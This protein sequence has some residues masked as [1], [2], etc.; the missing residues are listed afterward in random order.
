MDYLK[1]TLRVGLLVVLLTAFVEIPYAAAIIALLGLA[2]GV[3][4]DTG[5]LVRTFVLAIGLSICAGALGEIPAVG[6]Y[7]TDI[8]TSAAALAAASAVGVLGKWV[9]EQAGM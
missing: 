7:L 2:V 1:N 9:W 3:Q 4:R 6:G 8:L 5:D